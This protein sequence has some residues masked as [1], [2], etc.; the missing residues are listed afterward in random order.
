VV[1]AVGSPVESA[2]WQTYWQ[3]LMNQSSDPTDFQD[4]ADTFL[5][6]LLATTLVR[7]AVATVTRTGHSCPICGN[8]TLCGNSTIIC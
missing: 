3:N 1:T 2:Q 6:L 4:T 7:T 8:A 5:A